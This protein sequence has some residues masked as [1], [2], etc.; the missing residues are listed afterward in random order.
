[1]QINAATMENG[2]AV[3][4]KIK[5]IT[6][7]WSSNSPGYWCEGNKNTILH[8]ESSIHTHVHS[9]VT[10]NSQ[11]METNCVSTDRWVDKEILVHTYT[12]KIL[13]SNKRE[14]NPA[15]CDTMYGYWKHDA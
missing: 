9:S 12:H 10:D 3:S 6:T 11:D 8:I 13:F 5:I 15:T 1:M 4:Q 7:M 14:G 2:M